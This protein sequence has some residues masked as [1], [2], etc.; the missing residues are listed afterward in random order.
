MWKP[1]LLVALLACDALLFATTFLP[2]G[3]PERD[4]GSHILQVE[5]IGFV[6]APDADASREAVLYRTE[7]PV[8][9]GKPFRSKTTIGRITVTI[10]GRVDEA[11]GEDQVRLDLDCAYET[12]TGVSVVTKEGVSQ[13]ILETTA[14]QST[15]SVPKGEWIVIGG[16]DGI[17]EDRA[18][19]RYSRHHVRARVLPI[20]AASRP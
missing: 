4:D 19:K 2:A 16:S 14:S 20:D 18:G 17:T 9:L 5:T 10:G 1:A 8:E 15:I 12:E 11:R 3:A 7:L 13:P 6:N